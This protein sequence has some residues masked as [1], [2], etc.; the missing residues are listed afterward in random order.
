MLLG[1]ALLATAA[2]GFALMPRRVEKLLGDAKLDKLVPEN[3]AG[4]RYQ[5]ASG[6]VLPPADQL[7]DKIYSQFVTRAYTRADGAAVML[8]IA[9]SGA[10]DG[11]IQVHRPEICYPASGYKLTQIAGHET[12]LAPGLTIPS[13]YIVAEADLR[14]EQLIY[15]TRV[16]DYFPAKWSA[17][18]LA[19]IK[20]NFSGVIPDGVLVRMSA[21][22]ADDARGL[23]DSFAR[24]LYAAVGP[25]LRQVLVGLDRAGMQLK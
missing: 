3:F 23:L 19:V 25:R 22:G 12:P 7:R 4:W 9:Y 5:A 16:G 18:R 10:Q 8:L 2:A 6:L 20:E 17:Q 11:T 21:V 14:R 13:R 1:G 24:D 15:W